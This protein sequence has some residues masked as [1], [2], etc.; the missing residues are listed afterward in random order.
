MSDALLQAARGLWL[1][2]PE[3]GPKPLLL[4]LLLLAP[5]FREKVGERV[6]VVALIN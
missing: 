2:H 5:S 3:L 6:S 4:L 1:A